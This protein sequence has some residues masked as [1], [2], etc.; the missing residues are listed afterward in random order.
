MITSAH[1]VDVREFFGVKLRIVRRPIMRGELCSMRLNESSI[2][3]TG[4]HLFP[5]ASAQ[6]EPHLATIAKRF[7]ALALNGHAGSHQI[8]PLLKVDRTCHRATV[9]AHID[10]RAEIGRIEIPQCSGLLPHRGVLLF[11]HSSNTW[12]RIGF[13]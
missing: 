12:I 6:A 4:H 7:S 5:E 3:K 1:D 9:T 11:T 10:P 2:L 13:G 8:C